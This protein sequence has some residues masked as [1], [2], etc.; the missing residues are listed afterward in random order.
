MPA[1]GAGSTGLR[2]VLL[3]SVD[4]CLDPHGTK[5]LSP[6]GPDTFRCWPPHQGSPGQGDS[7][8][9]L[10]TSQRP[11]LPGSEGK[12]GKLGCVRTGVEEPNGVNVSSDFRCVPS[13]GRWLCSD[14]QL[15]NPPELVTLGSGFQPTPP[16]TFAPPTHAPKP[17]ERKC[18]TR[19]TECLQ[20]E[21]T[22]SSV[23]SDGPCELD[24]TRVAWKV[25]TSPYPLSGPLV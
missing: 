13:K 8:M 12:L 15:P 20:D 6:E 24:C 18:E 16:S 22:C 19:H 14:F 21:W 5:T 4:P 17:L 1:P 7:R 10:A 3:S 11:I 9:S 23:A 2:A 25:L